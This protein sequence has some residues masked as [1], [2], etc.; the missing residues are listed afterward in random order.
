[1][2]IDGNFDRFKGFNAKEQSAPLMLVD[3]DS[4]SIFYDPLLNND[5]EKLIVSPSD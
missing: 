1:M 4:N 2:F 5:F 3:I